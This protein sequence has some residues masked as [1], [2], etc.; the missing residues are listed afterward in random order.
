MGCRTGGRWD[1]LSPQAKKFEPMDLA[2]APATSHR[3]SAGPT[4]LGI[5]SWVL[6]CG[7]GDWDGWTSRE[8]S[9]GDNARRDAATDTPSSITVGM[10]G[11]MIR[12]LPAEIRCEGWIWNGGTIHLRGARVEEGA[13]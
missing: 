3:W 8:Q 4:L 1:I 5:L 11:M 12:G 7:P 9:I 6:A 2:T 13:S 10:M